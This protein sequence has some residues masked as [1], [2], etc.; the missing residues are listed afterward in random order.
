[1]ADLGGVMSTGEWDE[2]LLV[3]L[4]AARANGELCAE[5]SVENDIRRHMTTA[6]A[7][8]DMLEILKRIGDRSSHS[9][10]SFDGQPKDSELSKLKFLGISYGTLVGQTFASLYPEHLSRMVIDEAVDG[11]DWT[12]K[13]QMHLSSTLMP[14]GQAS[15]RIVS[16]PKKLVPCG[17][18]PILMLRLLRIG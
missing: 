15:T 17:E 12:G 9:S 8:R 2:G 3:R 5:Q 4:A 13:W 6:Y 16:W 10:D 18:H 14:F 11:N 1:M 7:T